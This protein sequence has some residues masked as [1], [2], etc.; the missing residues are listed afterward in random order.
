[1][2]DTFLHNIIWLRKQYGLSKKEMAHKLGIS[3]WMLNKIEK[4][5]LPPNL[6]IDVLFVIYKE[7]GVFM[8]DVLS[9]P[10]ESDGAGGGEK[11]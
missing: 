5:E 1:M 10:L 7:F 9:V 3:V 11:K 4:G 8:S 2:V 6:K